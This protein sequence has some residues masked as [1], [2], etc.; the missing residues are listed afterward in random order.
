VAR[1]VVDLLAGGETGEAYAVLAGR[2]GVRYEF[3]GVP[4]ARSA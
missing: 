2:G 3:R 1:V 4:G